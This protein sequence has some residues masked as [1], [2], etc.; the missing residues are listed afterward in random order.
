MSWI[1][2]V[3]DTRTALV[4]A[5]AKPESRMNID[6]L[7]SA[8]SQFS[9]NGVPYTTYGTAVA[10]PEQDDHSFL[11]YVQNGYKTDGVVFAVI[12]SRMLLFSEARFQYQRMRKG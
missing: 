12:L 7:A 3:K 5:S 2:R 8:W 11:D 10:N 9:F 6:D 4:G 1:E